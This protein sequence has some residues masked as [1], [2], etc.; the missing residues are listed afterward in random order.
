MEL[1]DQDCKWRFEAFE[2]A[3][4]NS[5]VQS[6]FDS[7]PENHRDHIKETLA[8]LQVTPRAYWEETPNFDPLIG[9]GGI[10]EIKLDPLM[11]GEGRFYYRMYGFFGPEEEGSY[12]FLHGTNKQQRND[13][14]GKATAKRRLD[15]ALDGQAAFHELRMDPEGPNEET[16]QGP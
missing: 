12:R 9:A 14:N 7:L 15:Q 16:E 8:F 5:P 1:G 3:E 13:R 2:S 4:E 6:W 11:S 10:S